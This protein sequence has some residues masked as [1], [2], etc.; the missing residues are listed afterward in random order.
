MSLEDRL[1]DPTFLTKL[2]WLGFIF[3]LVLMGL[4]LFVIMRDI[5][6]L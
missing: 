6:G 1:R 2:I 4:G 5:L 3:S